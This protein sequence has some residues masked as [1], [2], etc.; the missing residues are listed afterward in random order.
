MTEGQPQLVIHSGAFKT[1]TSA[2]QTILIS[3]AEML[4]S[5]QGILVPH[6]LSRPLQGVGEAGARSHNML[7]HL[8]K[9]LRSRD[10]GAEDRLKTQLAMLAQEIRSSGAQRAVISAELLT[11]IDETSATVIRDA[12]RGF[13]LRVVY[14]VR[15]VDEYFESLARQQLKLKNVS[16]KVEPPYRTPFTGLISWANVLGDAAVTALVYGYPSREAAVTNTLSAMGVQDAAGLVGENLVRNPSLQADGVLLRRALTRYAKKAGLD[17]S[18]RTLREDIVHRAYRLQDRLDTLK[19]LHVYSKGERLALFDATLAA[20]KEI[21]RRFLSPEQS[22]IFLA[23]K[24]IEALV[25]SGTPHWN[26]AEVM[27]IVD[28]LG[29]FVL[30][31][32][33]AIVPPSDSELE[34]LRK[35]FRLARRRNARLRDQVTVLEA[36]LGEKRPPQK[37]ND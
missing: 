11:N 29:K 4:L 7:G 30:E 22:E 1:A 9:S 27:Q 37:G 25:D 20:H 32:P 23:R 17:P 16:E 34:E 21:A 13:D 14:S 26:N 19:P 8:V 10:E 31:H 5:E 15:R 18:S 6:T 33:E 3:S 36:Q 2:V 12:L 28:E 35:A 24:P